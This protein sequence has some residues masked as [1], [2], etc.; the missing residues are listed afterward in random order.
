MAV[1]PGLTVEHFD[2]VI[3]VGTRQI[4]VFLN[5]LFD[6]LLFEAAEEGLCHR[7]VPAVAL[8]AHARLEVVLATEALPVVAAVLDRIPTTTA[9]GKRCLFLIP[10]HIAIVVL[11]GNVRRVLTE[12][13]GVDHVC[14]A[15]GAL[16]I[17]V[18][19]ANILVE[20]AK[21]RI[22]GV[23]NSDVI[24]SMSVPADIGH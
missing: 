3:D 23:S 18:L 9:Q 6:A 2:V 19:G 13:D 5:A 10:H 24:H 15:G 17:L 20:T 11:P 7:I 21:W 14:P 12:N 4:T 22:G 1:P 8:A 16:T